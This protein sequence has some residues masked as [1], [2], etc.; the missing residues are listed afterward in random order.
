MI[1][2]KANTQFKAVVVDNEQT[3][4]V[5]SYAQAYAVAFNLLYLLGMVREVKTE[6]QPAY[7]ELFL[8]ATTQTDEDNIL[9]HDLV[10]DLESMI[11]RIN[12]RS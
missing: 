9:S 12:R 8:P 11:A 7:I 4:V 2:L 5:L 3:S 6:D 1:T 10:P